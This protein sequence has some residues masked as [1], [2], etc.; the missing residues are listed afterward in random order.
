MAERWFPCPLCVSTLIPGAPYSAA[1]KREKGTGQVWD[2]S[3][4]PPALVQCTRCQGMFSKMAR[5]YKRKPEVQSCAGMRKSI[6]TK[7]LAAALLVFLTVYHAQV[8]SS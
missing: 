4:Q 1:A 5:R 7:E 6:R 2:L 8:I 3:A